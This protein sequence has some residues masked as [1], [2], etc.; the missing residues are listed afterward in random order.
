MKLASNVWYMQN[1]RKRV[2]RT[3]CGLTGAGSCATISSWASWGCAS[4]SWPCRAGRWARCGGSAGGT[5]GTTS[6]AAAAACD[7]TQTSYTFVLII[8]V[9]DFLHS[10]NFRNST[11]DEFYILIEYFYCA[12]DMTQ[13]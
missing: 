12:I 3:W 4:G 10:I 8:S 1:V 9:V 6:W 7:T 5:T 2:R 11:L 13:Y